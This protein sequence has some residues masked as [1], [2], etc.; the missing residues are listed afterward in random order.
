MLDYRTKNVH[1]QK[2][3][4]RLL[5]GEEWPIHSTLRIIELLAL[6]DQAYEPTN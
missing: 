4:L 6:R 2:Q 3:Y 1:I 5:L